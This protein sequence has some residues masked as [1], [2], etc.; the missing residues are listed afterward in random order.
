MTANEQAH[1]AKSQNV[2]KTLDDFLRQ[3][4]QDDLTK[5]QSFMQNYFKRVREAN[6]IYTHFK[7]GWKTDKGM[8]YIVFGRP[9]TIRTRA[10]EEVWVI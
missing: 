10:A 7:P 5:A 1:F 3:I 6:R 9:K 8:I 2:K 4:S